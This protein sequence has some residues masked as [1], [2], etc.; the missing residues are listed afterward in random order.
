MDLDGSSRVPLPSRPWWAPTFRILSVI[1]FLGF[2][3]VAFVFNRGD[4][5]RRGFLCLI[6]TTFGFALKLAPFGFTCT[7]RTVFFGEFIDSLHFLILLALSTLIISLIYHYHRIEP[8]FRLRP[9]FALSQDSIGVA[10]ALGSF[11]F[12][13]GMQFASGCA[14]GTLVGLGEGFVKSWI[15]IWFF[16]AGT[17]VGVMDPIYDWYSKLPKTAEPVVMPWYVTLIVLLVLAGICLGLEWR[18]MIRLRETRRLGD[19]D[20]QDLQIM[21][22]FGF[23]QE[24][25]DAKQPG[26]QLSLARRWLM[27]FLMAAA[28]GAYFL[29][30]G[31]PIGVIGAF[32]QIG[33]R[34]VELFGVDVAH[35]HYWAKS[36]LPNLLQ[37]DMV[38]SDGFI[39]IGGFL[40]AA[41]LKKFG[42]FQRNSVVHAIKAVVGGFL[43]GLGA[44]MAGGCNIGGMLSGITSSSL[45]GFVW[46]AC[47]LLGSYLGL[48]WRLTLEKH[49]CRHPTYTEID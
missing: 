41:A 21:M 39:A 46:L 20:L 30:E 33:C 5:W 40:A 7:F 8:L 3:A 12:G 15:A 44:R 17:T 4:P 1:L 35:W 23:N 18:R 31:R 37:S 24:A 11:L 48:L 22:T 32:T 45:H 34:F 43:M 14:S 6:S 16:I 38:L 36:K 29:C 42:T 27:D 9:T 28:I 47:A 49:F 19:M 25:D 26:F 10:L 2:T 13:I